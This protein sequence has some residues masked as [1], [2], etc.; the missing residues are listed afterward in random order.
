VTYR[1]LLYLSLGLLFGG[2]AAVQTTREPPGSTEAPQ[3]GLSYFLPKGSV[4]V[5]LS[6]NAELRSWNVIPTVIIEADPSERFNLDWSNSILSDKD[7]TISV[8]P[9]TG[10]LQTLDASTPGQ[11]VNT[12]GAIVGA[13]PNVLRL[14]SISAPVSS[15]SGQGFTAEDYLA[16]AQKGPT[17]AQNTASFPTSAQMVLTDAGTTSGTELLT[18]PDGSGGHWYGAIRARLTKRYDLGADFPRN[19]KWSL[20][21]KGRGGG[22]VVRLP[23]PYELS[24]E[25]T[26]SAD[27]Q[28]RDAARQYGCAIAPRMVMLPDS[29]HDFL[30]RMI[31]R[32]LVA[33]ATRVALTNGMIQSLEQVRPSMLAALIALPKYIVLNVAPIP[34]EV[35][36]SQ[37]TIS[38]AQSRL[39]S[40][41]GAAAT[42]SS[43]R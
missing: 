23:I 43:E 9:A 40:G 27:P 39:S 13:E 16:Y 32:P 15:Y 7:T 24:V 4:V 12:V 17:G 30:Y 37:Q 41:Q 26:I 2:C 11:S 20:D 5:G 31:G 19:R 42:T 33:D 38:N 28:F 3:N 14:G 21:E 8:D 22:F 34:V 25:E 10:L 1:L 29:Q 36:Q 35:T 6:W 18:V